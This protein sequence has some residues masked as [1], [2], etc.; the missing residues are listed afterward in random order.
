MPPH[1]KNGL[2]FVALCIVLGVSMGVITH[3]STTINDESTVAAT[4]DFIHESQIMPPFGSEVGYED[5]SESAVIDTTS[6]D[7]P[8]PYTPK[9][10]DVCNAK[11]LREVGAIEDPSS[12]MEPGEN[13]VDVT[14]FWRHPKTGDSYFC[15]HG[16]YCYPS[17]VS[18]DGK[19]A[20]AIKLLNCHLVI[21][22]EHC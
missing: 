15:Q 21:K 10:V 9:P 1:I 20:L 19:R 13:Y 16:G 12:K 14:Q 8:A 6:D 22:Q 5:T 11:V 18:I 3:L 2:L 7:D 17:H 4:E